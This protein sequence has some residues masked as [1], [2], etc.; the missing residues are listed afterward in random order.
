M[1]RPGREGGW[2]LVRTPPPKLLVVSLLSGE[3]ACLIIWAF[4]EAVFALVIGLIA[5]VS[6]LLLAL[7][8]DS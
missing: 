1:S 8:S 3:L 5:G 7:R 6:V 2:N 4:T